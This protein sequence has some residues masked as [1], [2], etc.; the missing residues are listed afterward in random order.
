[1]LCCFQQRTNC[2]HDGYQQ[3]DRST[4]KQTD[5]SFAFADGTKALA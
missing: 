1:V 4:G 2:Q 5:G 3:V